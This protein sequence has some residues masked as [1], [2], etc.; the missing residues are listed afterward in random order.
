ML[1]EKQ[2]V[3]VQHVGVFYMFYLC[4]CVCI[5]KFL[6]L[7]SLIVSEEFGFLYTEKATIFLFLTMASLSTVT[8]YFK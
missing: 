7:E 6:T 5:Y 8:I 3:E 2:D 1:Q 4:V